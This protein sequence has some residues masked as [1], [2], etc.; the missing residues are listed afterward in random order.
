MR[1]DGNI[2][3]ALSGHHLDDLAEKTDNAEKKMA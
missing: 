3:R 2:Q 1:M